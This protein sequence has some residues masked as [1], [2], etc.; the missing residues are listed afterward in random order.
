MMDLRLFDLLCLIVIQGHSLSKSQISAKLREL[1]L[2]GFFLVSVLCELEILS[3]PVTYSF[4]D[5][6]YGLILLC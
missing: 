5:I 6:H 3:C 4:G 2:L 1:Q